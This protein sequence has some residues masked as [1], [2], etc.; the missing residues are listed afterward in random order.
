MTGNGKHIG[1]NRGS[2]TARGA[3]LKHIWQ[4]HPNRPLF[5]ILQREDQGKTA[6]K[7]GRLLGAKKLPCPKLCY[8]IISMHLKRNARK[9]YKLKPRL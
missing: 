6:H 9:T 2:K 5:D 4:G 3:E 1:S 8:L 7:V